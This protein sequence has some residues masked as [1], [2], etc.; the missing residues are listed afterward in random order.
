MRV[1]AC[2]SCPG[3]R[4]ECHSLASNYKWVIITNSIAMKTNELHFQPKIPVA[5]F[6]VRGLVLDHRTIQWRYIITW[7]GSQAIFIDNKSCFCIKLYT[8]RLFFF[9]CVCGSRIISVLFFLTIWCTGLKIWSFH[10]AWVAWYISIARYH[11]LKLDS[12]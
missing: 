6:N 1:R 8:I 5:Q 9:L 4:G 3:W 7:F 12:S 10:L 11:G 2:L